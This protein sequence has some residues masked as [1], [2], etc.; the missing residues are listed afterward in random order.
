MSIMAS[1]WAQRGNA[2][3][4]VT[5]ADAGEDFHT[6]RGGVCR[7]ALGLTGESRGALDAVRGNARRIRA[8]RA[9]FRAAAPEIVVSFVDITNVLAVAATRGLRAPVIISERTDPDHFPIGRMWNTLRRIAYPLAD[10]LVVQSEGMRAWGHAAMG[11]LSRVEVIANP[12]D[13]SPLTAGDSAAASG[14]WR[15]DRRHVLAIGRLDDGK[16]FH[17]LMR[18]FADALGARPEWDLV[19]MGE[20][21]ERHALEKL[22]GE[23]GLDGRVHLPGRVSE[24]WAV[25]RAADMLV[26]SS[27]FE[28]FPNVILEA[29]AHG[30][31][32]VS[33]DCPIGPRHILTHG[34][35]GLLVPPE[36]VPMLAAAIGRVAESDDLRAG[37][38]A[39]AGIA[40][41]RY[42][43]ASVM[44]RWNQ[45]ILRLTGVRPL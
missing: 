27:R 28:G 23:L 20:G 44:V 1:W 30:V 12:V 25:G 38:A 39:G 19:I 37:L 15:P 26:L 3:T 17:L 35:D 32:P 36:D 2:V 14:F 9:A 7:V 41:Q 40:A 22:R 5:L 43:T 4:L 29:M 42:A 18:A 8:L 45:L 6:L 10:T 11:D 34:K 24:P 31:P 13:V 33:F 21:P 16:A